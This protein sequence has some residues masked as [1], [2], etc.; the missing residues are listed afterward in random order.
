MKLD[1][2]QLN[3][4]SI[5]R[6]SCSEKQGQVVRMTVCLAV[7]LLALFAMACRDIP[8]PT[9]EPAAKLLPPPSVST[10][11]VQAPEPTATLP[12]TPQPADMHQAT[13]TPPRSAT[14]IPAIAPDFAPSAAGATE[15]LDHAA[16]AQKCGLI[17]GALAQDP[18]KLEESAADFTWGELAEDLQ[19]VES[20]YDQLL[21]PPDLEVF[22]ATRL[23]M[24][25]A[26]NERASEQPPE[27]L[28]WDDYSE[29][30]AALLPEIV[31][32]SLDEALTTVGREEKAAQL[33]EEHQEE[34][35]GS[36][37]VR[38]SQHQLNVWLALPENLRAT[39]KEGGCTPDAK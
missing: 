20:F 21:P 11:T 33:L 7:A 1:M 4:E 37:F 15:T 27:A 18:S 6:Q 14:E 8:A 34:F 39:L 28:I 16:Y 30:L 32:I 19:V 38:A 29:G 31:R 5:S 35:Y 3:Q 23:T 26:L 13:I 22:H 17:N 36:E 12:P 10:A 25:R 9:A 24:V 2:S